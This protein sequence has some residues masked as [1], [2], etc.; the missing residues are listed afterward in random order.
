[1]GLRDK[2]K[3]P[4]VGGPVAGVI[5]LVAVAYAIFGGGADP[6]GRPDMTT[7]WYYD[8]NTEK[9]YPVKWG[10]VGHTHIPPQPA[11]S[12]P[13][14]EDVGPL[15][16][17]DDAGVRAMNIACGSCENEQFIGRLETYTQEVGKMFYQDGTFPA[18]ELIQANFYFRSHEDKTWVLANSEE[19]QIIDAAFTKRC[20]DA[21]KKIVVCE[22]NNLE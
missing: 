4:K 13:L 15:K 19:A 1:M 6:T 2:M 12:G 18:P 9:L 8:L 3:D 7:V 5:V 16:K 20:R 14:K 17:G 21:G 22:P 11:P 10:E